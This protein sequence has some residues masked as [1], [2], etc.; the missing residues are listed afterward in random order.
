MRILFTISLLLLAAPILAQER[1]ISGTLTGRDGFPL[2]GVSIT[3]K[4]TAIG[5]ST[6]ADGYYS[7]RAQVG[8]TLVFSFVGMQTREVV[9]TAENFKGGSTSNKTDGKKRNDK[10]RKPNPMQPIPRSLYNDSSTQEHMPGIAVLTDR[11]ASFS[12]MHAIDPA[13]IRAI[14]ETRNGYTI[15]IDKTP[16][17][18]RGFGLQFS[19]SF[20]VE[21]INKLPS[22]QPE[23]VQGRSLEGQEQWQGPDNAEIFSWG[24]SLYT[25]EYDGSSYPYDHRGKLVP[26]GTGNG[27][28]AQVHKPMDFFR[29]GT[30]VANELMVTLPGPGDGAFIF[31]VENRNRTSV[32]PNS[33]YRR[34]NISGSLK[35]VRITSDLSATVTASFNNS[36]GSLL[37]KGANF[38]SIL[39]GVYRSPVSFDNANGLPAR[40]A[41]KFSEAFRLSDGSIRSHAP[42]LAD[43]P[44]GLAQELPD[45]DDA[46]RRT[47]GIN[48]IY[49]PSYSPFNLTF[50]GNVDHQSSDNIFGVPT[51]YSSYTSG[52][53]SMRKEN[54]TFTN[55]IITPAYRSYMGDGELKI[56]LSYQLQHTRRKLH[57]Q[58]GFGFQDMPLQDIQQTDSATSI[59]N[60]GTRTIQEIVFNAHF[61]PYHFLTVRLNN[62]NYFSSTLTSKKYTNFFPTASVTID[63]AELLHLSDIH[64][65]DLYSSYSKTLR[66]APLIYSDW[67]YGS[68]V[69]P[70]EKY[71]GFFEGTE[72]FH[73]PNLLPETE[74]KLE[75]GIK[76]HDW[77]GLKVEVSYFHNQ[78]KN[79][80]IPVQRNDAFVLENVAT[81]R[82]YGVSATAHYFRNLGNI[83]LATDL[84]WSSYNSKADKIYGPQDRIGLAGFS[85]AQVVLAQDQP[86]GAIYGTSYQRN[87]TGKIIIGDDGFPLEDASMKRIGNPIPDWTLGWSSNLNWKKFN[88]STLID[89]K[90]GGDVWN[91][92][93]ATLDYLGRSSTT[94][95]LRNTTNYIFEG[96]TLDGSTNTQSVSFFD[97]AKS[98]TENRWVRYGWD[99]IGENYIEDA[100]WVRLNELA[101]SY[102]PNISSSNTFVKE[103]KFSIIGRNLFVITPYSGVDPSSTLFGYNAGRGLDLFNAPATRSYTA[104]VTIK[105]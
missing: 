43:N 30:H 66:E 46:Q 101:L 52:R 38:A 25:L 17:R 18:R 92:T 54:Q 102:S 55:A 58:D 84:V 82:N 48:I 50:N 85:S 31:D 32:I 62:R 24:P 74:R 19:S 79:L 28:P 35:N 91:G 95:A 59:V 2:P 21:Q 93:A 94:G 1:T 70:V 41:F 73:N 87:E 83:T 67:A 53:L 10:K 80:I 12:P 81:V 33:W 100:S 104:Q 42:G 39:G 61:H 44:N 98:I 97:P 69:L 88:L 47:G 75:A 56:S 68:T 105:I 8:Q 96:V 34:Y 77:S 6:D 51:G 71:T 13:A 26:V 5:T 103:I 78:T 36:K 99:G 86:V 27:S 89:F 29:T 7:I 45:H 23:F 63:L 37:N 65:L 9:V 40:K 14:N 11:T 57:R 60:A 15:S 76:F 90:K 49:N 72:L 64:Y 20:G 3:I 22:L 4:G 16:Y